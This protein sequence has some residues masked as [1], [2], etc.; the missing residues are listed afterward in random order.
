MQFISM[1]FKVNSQ[2]CKVTKSIL[3]R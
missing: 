3:K 1:I 2:A